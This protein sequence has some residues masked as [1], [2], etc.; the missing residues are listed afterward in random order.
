MKK[1]I[2]Y[3]ALDHFTKRS[4]GRWQGSYKDER[5]GKWHYVSD[6]D[7]ERLHF[8]ILEKQKPP[9]V[10]FR[11]MADGWEAKHREDIK[12]RTWSNYKP[13]KDELADLYGKK[14]V[15]DI[16]ATIIDQDLK[17]LKAKDYSKTVVNTRKVVWSGILDYALSEGEIP[18]NPAMSVKLP[19]GLKQGKRSAPEDDVVNVIVSN[20]EDMDFGFIPFFLLCTGMRRTEALTTRTSN[21]DTKAWEIRIPVAKTEAGVRTVPIVKPLRAPLKAWMSAHPGPWLF[22]YVSYNKR[23]GEHMTDSNWER[24]WLAYCTRYG[25]LDEK[26]NAAIGAH[27]LRHGTAT[28]LF[29]SGVDVYTAQHILG[30]ANVSTTM[31]IYTELRRKQERKGL[32]RFSRSM[33]QRM[34]KKESPA[35]SQ[36]N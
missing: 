20:A 31:E 16:T 4:D 12:D 19:K 6:P 24:A 13:H 15:K 7:P 22:P 27:H 35:E 30:H 1:K 3:V 26:G 25:W 10:T 32:A 8:R 11:E 33:A 34:A 18:F 14:A 36:D 5:T 29:E 2:D 28:L 21:V 17:S 23:K 9:A